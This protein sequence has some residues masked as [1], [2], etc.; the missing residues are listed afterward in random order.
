MSEY[1][2]SSAVQD[3]TT[4][5]EQLTYEVAFIGNCLNRIADA[6]TPPATDRAADGRDGGGR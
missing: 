6:L 2:T 1:P 3:L 4:R 5:M